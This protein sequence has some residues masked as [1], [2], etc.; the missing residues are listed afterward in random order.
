VVAGSGASS[1]AAADLAGHPVG[2]LGARRKCLQADRGQPLCV[3]LWEQALGDA[4]LRLEAVRVIEPDEPVGGVEDRGQRTV[5]L[6]QDDGPG[7]P[8]AL[9][10]I[11]DVADRGAAELVDRLVVVADDRHVAVALGEQRDELGLR[12]VGVLELVN[13]DVPEA[14][15]ERLPGRSRFAEE[16]EGKRNLVAEVD[17]PGLPQEP[18]VAGERSRQLEL[19]ASILGEG[20]DAVALSIACLTIAD[21]S[22]RLGGLSAEVLGMLE[23]GRRADILVLA[24]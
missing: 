10:K 23:I 8:V 12:S 20:I 1:H 19:A 24:A 6:S 16:P 9:L 21:G 18:L 17:E 22:R 14:R 3:P 5:V 11:E 7:A 4:D 13:K 2:F 15:L